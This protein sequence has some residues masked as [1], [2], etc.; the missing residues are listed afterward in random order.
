MKLLLS[1]IVGAAIGALIGYVVWG[2]QLD[3]V[4]SRITQLEAKLA[5]PASTPA[6]AAPSVPT[7][8]TAGAGAA[9]GKNPNV[10]IITVSGAFGGDCKAK[11]YPDRIGNK[12][13]YKVFWV[14]DGDDAACARGNWR[15][16]L[17]F[18]NDGN[19]VYNGDQDI[20]VPR[21]AATKYKIK[22]GD[23]PGIFK[24]RIYYVQTSGPGAPKR[25]QMGDPELEIEM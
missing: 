16:E 7:I 14:V 25:Y 21:D 13:N 1:L 8:E 9:F 2:R 15:V 19:T 5:E 10:A 17:H 3:Q 23:N 4:N 6:P 11:V 24:Y 22:N 18:E 12:R 20:T